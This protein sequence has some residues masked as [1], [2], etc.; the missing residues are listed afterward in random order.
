VFPVFNRSVNAAVSAVDVFSHP[1]FVFQAGL[2][3]YYHPGINIKKVHYDSLKL[4]EKLE[5]ETGQVSRLTPHFDAS[6]SVFYPSAHVSLV[7][8]FS[9]AGG[10]LPSARQRPHRR[11]GGSSG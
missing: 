10:G 1:G 6:M 8:V 4:Y 3:T 2:T 7:F 11:N 9:S 5:A